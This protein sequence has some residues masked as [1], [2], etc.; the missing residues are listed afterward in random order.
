MTDPARDALDIEQLVAD[1]LKAIPGI[2][3]FLTVSELDAS[4]ARLA[5]AYP[6][7]VKLVHVGESA[8]GYPIKALIIG[9]T[10]PGTALPLPDGTKAALLFGCPHP[11]EPIGAMMLEHFSA[12]LA[13]NPD[14]VD[15]LGYT[16]YMVKCIDPDG[17][18]LN[19]GW[20]KGPFT[21]TNYAT[22]F[23]R[24][25]GHQQVEW[26]FPI[27]YKTLDYDSPIPETR[28]LMRMIEEIKPVF[29]FSLHNAGF[30]GVYY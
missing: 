12:Q 11:N 7:R 16:W 1:A 23:Y 6:D 19:E 15:K 5:A 22:H 13:A 20:F 3:S 27:K 30:G 24:P 26:N 18:R 29:M 25:A 2:D 10:K 21:I 8:D 17:T 14:L 4:S 9:P 28:A